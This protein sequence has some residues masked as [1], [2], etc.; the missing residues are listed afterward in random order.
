MINVITIAAIALSALPQ[1]HPEDGRGQDL[2]DAKWHS[3]RRAELL[4]HFK[5]SDPG[6]VILRGKASNPDY[7]EFRQDN[8]FWYFT[9][10]TTPNAILVMTTDTRKEYLF[11][12][13]VSA[14]AERWQGDLVDPDEAKAMTG[15]KNCLELGPNSSGFGATLDHLRGKYKIAYIQRQPAEN[16]MMSRDNLQSAVR[17]MMA[18]P[19]DAGE[20][21]EARFSNNLEEIHDFKVKD[22]SVTLDALRVVKTPE[23][24]EA[25]RMAC[26]ASS[27]GHTAVMSSSLPG[28][29]EWQLAS[30]MMYEFQLAGG[31]GQGGYA[32]IVASEINACTLHYNENSRSLGKNEVIMIDYG[33]EYNHY[34]ADISRTWPTAKKFTKRQ[35]EV[36]QAVYDAQ[37]AAFEMCKPGKTLRDVSNAAQKVITKRGFGNMWHGTSHW[38][39][40]ATHDVGRFGAKLEPGMAFTVEPGIYLPEERIGVRIE[41][42]VVITEDGYELISGMIPRSI[43][44]IEALRA[45]AYSKK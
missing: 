15:I 34:V 44:E 22:I 31:M 2:F 10:V 35:R 37:E 8:N 25:M 43:E 12:P 11:V 41:D 20:H 38:L 14:G 18:N 27:A 26:A 9:G 33:A 7:R 6:V 32:P 16:W 1:Q 5:D 23:E 4:D 13:A 17:E 19:Y 24:V 45:Q 29:Y 36:Y 3:G 40:M 21:R 42:V 30:R 39:G 28:D